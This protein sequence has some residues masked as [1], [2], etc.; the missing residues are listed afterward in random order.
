[1]MEQPVALAHFAQFLLILIAIHVPYAF[2]AL[3]ILKPSLL[4]PPPPGRWNGWLHQSH[5]RASLILTV[6]ACGL[7]VLVDHMPDGLPVDLA[8][9]GICILALLTV[10]FHYRLS[11]AALSLAGGSAAAAAVFLWTRDPF[12]YGT[13]VLLLS[14]AI[15]ACLTRSFG[16]LGFFVAIGICV[17]IG[18]A[19]STFS[20]GNTGGTICAWPE[21]LR[22]P[23]GANFL[24]SNTPCRMD[25]EQF[26]AEHALY[27]LGLAL[28]V[29]L[30]LMAWCLSF[31]LW[32]EL[33]DAWRR[34]FA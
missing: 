3:L 16:P 31:A 32:R 33:S 27:A 21:S 19:L 26:A 10:A 15:M 28:V 1:M 23:V 11:A 18:L 30:P 6:V 5:P 4:V 9:G 2:L 34:R 14:T 13:V 7:V 12:V 8:L 17:P 25:W 29:L 22:D 24:W 20:G